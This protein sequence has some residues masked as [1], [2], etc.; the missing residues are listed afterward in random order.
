M[1]HYSMTDDWAYMEER[2]Q[3]GELFGAFV[4]GRLAGFAGVH[5]EGSLG[6]LE[7]YVEDRR[8]GIGRALE[9]FLV[10]RH[11]SMGY[12]PYGNVV[13]GNGVSLALQGKLGLCVSKQLL[14][15][16]SLKT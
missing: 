5:A 1:A 15:W 8:K 9:S 11:L 4:D 12:T 14:Y 7:V 13:E 16:V 10:N 6:M 3:S 2:L